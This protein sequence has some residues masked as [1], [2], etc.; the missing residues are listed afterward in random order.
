MPVTI[1][2]KKIGITQ[3]FDKSG[4][5]YPVTILETKPCKVLHRYKNLHRHGYNAFQ[6]AYNT[7][8]SSSDKRGTAS[9]KEKFM[10]CPPV[11]PTNLKQGSLVALEALVVGAKVTTTARTIGKGFSGNQKRHNFTIGPK[12]HGS[13]NHRKPGSI[14]AGTT[15][16]RVFP[17]KKMAGRLGNR[18]L[19]TPGAE[20]IYQNQEKNILVL[21]GS[22]P[23]KRGTLVTIRVST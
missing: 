6:V 8:F 1:V 5:A 10:E 12:T 7:S 17:G 2:A 21:K 18:R 15:P 11:A 19:T 22:T 20:V 16:G 13:K 14:G 9:S 23:G 4:T 3:I